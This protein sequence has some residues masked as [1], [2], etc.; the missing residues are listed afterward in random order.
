[1]SQT[2]PDWLSK[3]LAGAILGFGLGIAIPGLLAWLTP[4]GPA[5]TNKF[6]F[7]MWLSSPIWL[8]VLSFCYFFSSGRQAWLWLG[9]ANAL[10]F[11]G[12]FACRQLLS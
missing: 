2:R 7:V 8:G 6:Q 9:A 1:M 11:A 4:G 3:T 10:S 12:L 5:A